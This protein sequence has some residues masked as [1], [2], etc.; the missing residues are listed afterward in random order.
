MLPAELKD[1]PGAPGVKVGEVVAVSDTVSDEPHPFAYTWPSATA[2]PE[3]A[4]AMHALALRALA[5]AAHATFGPAAAANAK[6]DAALKQAADSAER[7]LTPSPASSAA[8]GKRRAPA[9]AKPVA[10]PLADPDFRA[11]Q[12]SYDGVVTYVYSAHTLG[13]GAARRYVTVIAQ[14]DF[15]GK[16]H[17][18]L[19]ETTRGDMLEQTPALRLIDAVDANGD[20]RAELLFDEETS[21]ESA[22]AGAPARR[23]VLYNVTAGQALLAYATVP[24]AQQ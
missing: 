7:S 20:H 16:P 2:A 14:P 15:Y 10:D 13:E 3:A 9:P 19:T 21:A 11:F 12:L 4:L 5:S 23:F 8:A 17:A 1:A 22:V 18:V 24:G 6:T